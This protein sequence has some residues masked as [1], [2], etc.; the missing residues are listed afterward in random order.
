MR[1]HECW[2]RLSPWASSTTSISL[3]TKNTKH[4]VRR[5]NRCH[6]AKRCVF[7]TFNHAPDPL[8]PMIAVT[9]FVGK[10]SSIKFNRILFCLVATCSM[11]QSAS[12]SILFEAGIAVEWFN[13]ISSS[14]AATAHRL[15]L[16][17]CSHSHQEIWRSSIKQSK[18]SSESASPWI[19]FR[20]RE[21]QNWRRI[22]TIL[23]RPFESWC[24]SLPKREKMSLLP[25]RLWHL[26]FK[27][28][29]GCVL[30]NTRFHSEKA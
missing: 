18:S 2:W 19:Q 13:Q 25:W 16:G 29:E 12:L 28:S 1:L 8:G 5:M 3:P 11:M 14:V 21:L 4:C 6:L 24:H 27:N 9:L 20:W 30:Y 10:C 22:R 7:T 17:L 23:K 26:P 15:G